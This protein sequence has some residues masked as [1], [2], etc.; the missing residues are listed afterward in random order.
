MITDSNVVAQEQGLNCA[1]VYLQ[2]APSNDKYK[3][4]LINTLKQLIHG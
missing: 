3:N 1:F 2:N 4:H